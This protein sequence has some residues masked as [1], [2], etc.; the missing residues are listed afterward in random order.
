M[1]LYTSMCCAH[2]PSSVARNQQQQRYRCFRNKRPYCKLAVLAP[3]PPNFNVA[4]TVEEV[5]SATVGIKNAQNQRTRCC[6]KPP[7]TLTLGWGGGLQKLNPS[8]DG[9]LFL[10]HRTQGQTSFYHDFEISTYCN[11]Q[12]FSL[13]ASSSLAGDDDNVCTLLHQGVDR[14]CNMDIYL[15]RE[16]FRRLLSVTRLLPMYYLSIT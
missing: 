14:H 3:P 15:A 2:S 6:A 11:K 4:W 13:I 10:K 1:H 5:T 16:L 9:R 12:A 8:A 7:R